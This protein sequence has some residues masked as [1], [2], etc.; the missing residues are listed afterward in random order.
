MEL[1]AY[2]KLLMANDPFA[3]E[4]FK[5][6]QVEKRLSKQRERIQVAKKKTFDTDVRVNQQF[7][8]EL[9][10]QNTSNKRGKK[11]TDVEALMTDDR[12]KMMF[13]DEE[14]KRDQNSVGYKT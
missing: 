10:D 5:K 9:I 6:D 14:F 12:F 7:V 1:K 4:K 11:N 3:Y 2:Q 13:E 8:D